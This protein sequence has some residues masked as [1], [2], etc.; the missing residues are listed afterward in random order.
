MMTVTEISQ[1]FADITKAASAKFELAQC[2]FVLMNADKQTEVAMAVALALQY[3]IKNGLGLMSNRAFNV[4]IEYPPI[5]IVSPSE[6]DPATAQTPGSI[7][8][9]AVAPQLGV[10]SALWGGLF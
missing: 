7:R 10:Q 4:T 1:L 2:N 3:Q 9:A 8:L 6:F 5:R